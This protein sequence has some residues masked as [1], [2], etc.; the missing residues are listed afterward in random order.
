MVRGLVQMV[1]VGLVLAVLLHGNLPVGV[2]ILLAMTFATAVTASRRAQDIKGSLLL[3]FYAIAA[4]SGVVIAGMLATGTLTAD[5]AVLVPVG[6]MIIANAMNACAQSIER[7]RADVTAHVGQIEAGLAL[8]ADPGVTVAPYVAGCGLCQPPPSSRY[9]EVA[10][11]VWIP[12]VMA[13]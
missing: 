9:A 2:L 12:G 11:L 3:S 8:G 6:S 7:F 4:G 5:I 1:F 13:A 10:R